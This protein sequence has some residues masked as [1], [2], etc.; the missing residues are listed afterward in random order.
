MKKNRQLP[1]LGAESDCRWT[2]WLIQ[3]TVQWQWNKQFFLSFLRHRRGLSMWLS[4]SP[5]DIDRNP[6]SIV[7]AIQYSRHWHLFHTCHRKSLWNMWRCRSQ[8]KED[9]FVVHFPSN[10]KT[11]PVLRFGRQLLC[12]WPQP[13]P[14]Q[15]L[16]AL[17][18]ASQRLEWGCGLYIGLGKVPWRQK[19]CQQWCSW[20]H[21]RRQKL[22]H[23]HMEV[24]LRAWGPWKE[25]CKC[26][27]SQ[28]Q[29][30]EWRRVSRICLS[31]DPFHLWVHLKII[32]II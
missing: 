27:P 31:T 16:L 5:V 11:M 8:S 26:F 32:F 22:L 9:L 7:L 19:E 25:R 3:W 28:L 29:S 23:L 13:L 12:S 1:S 20:P 6:I 10:T 18:P 30:Q 21:R 24:C 4:K 17:V 14:I 15:M 2:I